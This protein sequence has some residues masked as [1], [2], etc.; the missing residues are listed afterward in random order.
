MD[1][2][3]LR[4]DTRK[5]SAI[6]ALLAVERRPYARDELAAMFWP[7]SDDESARSALRRTLSVLRAALGDRWLRVDRSTVALAAHGDGVW[8]DLAALEAGRV[9]RRSGVARGGRGPR[10]RPVPRRVLAARQPG[11][12]RLAR[13]PC[14][15]RGAAHRRRAGAARLGGGGGRRSGG[16]GRGGHA[17][18]GAGSARRAR[19]AAADGARSRA[20]V[21]GPGPI[22]QYRATVAMLERELGVAPLARRPSCTRRS[23]TS[24]SVRSWSRRA[25]VASSRRAGGSSAPMRQ[26]Q[27][28]DAGPAPG[29]GVAPR[30]AARLVTGRARRHG[31]RARPGSASPA[32]WRPCS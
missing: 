2:E 3:P 26:A 23:G 24:G 12:R 15:H 22:R 28:A 11:L 7:E 25:P 16:G 29:A 4:V 18:R 19:A 9:A 14:R 32:S 17:A 1:G 21:T 27:A 20:A 5:A 6:V 13:H 10:A 30:R 31:H 8:L